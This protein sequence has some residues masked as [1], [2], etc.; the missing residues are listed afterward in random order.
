[1]RRLIYTGFVVCAL[2]GLSGQANAGT[3]AFGGTLSVQLG[4]LPPVA[5]SNAG[6][7]T[8]NGGPVLNEYSIGPHVSAITLGTS[9]IAGSASTVTAGITVRLNAVLGS[10]LGGIGST[11]PPGVSLTDKTLGAISG[12]VKVTTSGGATTLPLSGFDGSWTIKTVTMASGAGTA[13]AKGFQHGPASASSTV[14]LG[15]AANAGVIQLVS[16][17]VV[18]GLAP[19]NPTALPATLRFKLVP[20]PGLLLLL[21]SGV[22]G[23]TLLGRSRMRK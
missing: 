4:G 8:M 7:A 19:L 12:S 20:E 5:V 21:G 22:V 23:L 11:S 17:G 6:V 3:A 10:D 1:M 14:A 16:P 2:I 13:T 9:A 15:T 18:T